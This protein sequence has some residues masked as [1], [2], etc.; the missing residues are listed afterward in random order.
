[1]SKKGW[2]YITIGVLTLAAIFAMEYNKPK[3]SIGI[4]RMYPIIKYPMALTY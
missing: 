2:V 4:L 3:K 1:M